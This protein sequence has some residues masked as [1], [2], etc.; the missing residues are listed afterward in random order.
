MVSEQTCPKM[1]AAGLFE[2]YVPVY[3]PHWNS[4]EDTLSEFTSVGTSLLSL[5]I[6]SFTGMNQ[7]I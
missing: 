1:E 4:P 6:D 7:E 5:G 3:Q 2:M